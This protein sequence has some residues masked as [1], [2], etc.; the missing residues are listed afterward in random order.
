MSEQ[1]GD[2]PERDDE[3]GTSLPGMLADVGREMGSADDGD[4]EAG[5]A[6]NDEAAPSEGAI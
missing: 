1:P 4:A 6:K 5:G 3:S 2:G